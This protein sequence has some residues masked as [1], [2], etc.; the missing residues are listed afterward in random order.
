MLSVSRLEMIAAARV[1]GTASYFHDKASLHKRRQPGSRRAR[2]DMEAA[3]D[4]GGRQAFAS[5]GRESGE[6]RLIALV[7]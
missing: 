7:Y 1:Q 5:S 2:G 4:F 6:D 3:G